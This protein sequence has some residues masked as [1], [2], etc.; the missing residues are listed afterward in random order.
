MN[1]LD[2][3]INTTTKE[4]YWNELL[5]YSSPKY[6]STIRQN[7]LEYGLEIDPKNEILLKN[8]VNA[9]VHHKWQFT[10][11]ARDTIREICKDKSNVAFFTNLISSLPIDEQVQ[12][13]RLLP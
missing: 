8:L 1:L 10:K 2:K 5:K 6:E 11:F 4:A 9:T 3:N 13:K 7:A 12:L